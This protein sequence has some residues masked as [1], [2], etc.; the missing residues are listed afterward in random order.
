MIEAEAAEPDLFFR[1]D[2]MPDPRRYT[3][4]DR[5]AD[6]VENAVY[7]SVTEFLESHKSEIIK[8]LSEKK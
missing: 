3:F 6:A 1:R 8:A 5:I 4:E 7:K 2:E